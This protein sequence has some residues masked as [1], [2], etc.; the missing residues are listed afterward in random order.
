MSVFGYGRTTGNPAYSSLISEVN[1]DESFKKHFTEKVLVNANIPL[2]SLAIRRSII[3][4]AK[5]RGGGFYKIGVFTNPYKL[6]R[7]Y[8]DSVVSAISMV[9]DSQLLIIGI[10]KVA[11][12]NIKSLIGSKVPYQRIIFF[13]RLNNSHYKEV[14]NSLDL[15]VDCPFMGGGV[16]PIDALAAGIPVVTIAST[17]L[18]EKGMETILL[19]LGMS[20]LIAHSTLDLAST[21]ARV[22]NNISYW[23]NFLKNALNQI[24]LINIQNQLVDKFDNHLFNDINN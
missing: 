3:G 19:N 17:F 8:I 20:D 12:Q 22:V 21:I 5:F 11:E 23:S 16:A 13:D 15:V 18:E 6:N 7:K 24:N 9:P 2:F 1:V 4:A 10:N 14:L